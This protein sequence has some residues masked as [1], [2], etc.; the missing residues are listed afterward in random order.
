MGWG[1]GLDIHK[2]IGKVQK[3]K[4]GSGLQEIINTWDHITH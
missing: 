1:A 4:A 2:L 3:Q